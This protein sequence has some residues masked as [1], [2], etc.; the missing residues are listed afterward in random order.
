M[1]I[2]AV[3]WSKELTVYALS[4]ARVVGL[5]PTKSIDIGARLFCLY[6]PVCR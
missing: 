2:S 4:N 5:N 1:P 3:V 6:F